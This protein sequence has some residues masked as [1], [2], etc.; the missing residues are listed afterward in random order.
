MHTVSVTQHVR[1]P[2]SCV[3]D[4][5]VDEFNDIYKYNPNLRHSRALEGGPAEIGLGS[6]RQC[7]LKDGRNWI[8]ETIV[9]FERDEEIVV[10][11]YDGS[12]PL[13]KAVAT[14]IFE[15]TEADGTLVNV[16]MDFVP[17][18]GVLGRLMAPM[19]KRRFSVVLKSLL[20]ANARYVEARRTAPCAQAAAA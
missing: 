5:W 13:K 10:D 15:S 18:Y 4:T 2:R 6:R 9:G 7:D 12:L 3:F 1:A 11:I 17:R 19:M 16:R 8:R 14:F 20:Q